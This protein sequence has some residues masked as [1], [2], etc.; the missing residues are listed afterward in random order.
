MTGLDAAIAIFRVRL[1]H[2][3]NYKSSFFLAGL[4]TSLFS[5]CFCVAVRLCFDGLSLTLGV[6]VGFLSEL[7]GSI[8]VAFAALGI[9]ASEQ[10]PPR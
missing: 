7:F 5:L 8:W 9:R 4:H 3:E 1:K 10:K 6:T 2:P